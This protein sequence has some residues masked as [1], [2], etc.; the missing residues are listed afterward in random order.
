MIVV[1]ALSCAAAQD[2]KVALDAQ[3]MPIAQAMANLSKQAGIQIICD[4]GV[5]GTVT[6]SFTSIEL[7]SLLDSITKANGLKWQKLYLPT[8][9]EEQKPTLE[10]VKAQAAAVAAVSG[11]AMVVYD[12]ATGKQKVFVEQPKDTPS[13]DPDKLGLKPVYLVSLPQAAQP[14]KKTTTAAADTD[15]AALEQQRMNML[16]GMTPDQRVQA[17]QQEMIQMLALDPSTRQQLMMD[18]MRARHEMDPQIREQLHQTMHD[19]FRSMRDQG[20][21][22]DFHGR[23]DRGGRDRGN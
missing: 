2:A 14:A 7:E 8:P 15:Y 10:Q 5:S 4:T 12:P 11:G 23:G 18:Q 16:A 19:T 3:D 20:M 22:P 6:G 21:V 13:V 17:M 9:S 1:L